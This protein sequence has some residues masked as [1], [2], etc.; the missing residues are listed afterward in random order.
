MDAFPIVRIPTPGLERPVRIA[1]ITDVHIGKFT[2]DDPSAPLLRERMEELY[3]KWGRDFEDHLGALLRRAGEGQADAV[4]LTGDAVNFPA[5]SAI[6][7]TRALFDSCPCPVFF[8]S[9]NHDW[10]FPYQQPCDNALRITQLPLA[11]P[12]FHEGAAVGYSV[13]DLWGLQ[14][15]SVDNSTYQ[16]DAEQLAF[17]RQRLGRG[18]PTVILMHIPITQQLLRE[19]AIAFWGQPILMGADMN[20]EARRQWNVEKP[21]TETADFVSLLR[22]APNLRAVFCGHVH[23]EHEEQFSPAA[24]QYV[25]A[26]AYEGGIRFFEFQPA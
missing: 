7:F 18:I 10:T 15:L 5:P 20:A 23:F 9:G 21:A 12:L 25:G 4:F 26:P 8:I 14:V 1:H 17:V 24:M 22:A 19:R 3:G 16:I 13:Q 11:A 2:E 6:E